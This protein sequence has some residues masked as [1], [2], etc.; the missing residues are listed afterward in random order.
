MIECPEFTVDEVTDK[1]QTS[2]KSKTRTKPAQ[3]KKRQKK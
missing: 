3:R 1:E 2:D